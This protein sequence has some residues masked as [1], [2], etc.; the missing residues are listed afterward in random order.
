[1][2]KNPVVGPQPPAIQR[3]QEI[4]A[5]TL[6]ILGEYEEWYMTQFTT[7]L[8][9]D[10]PRLYVAIVPGVGHMVNMEAPEIFN[11]VVLSFLSDT[12]SA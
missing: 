10:M 7:L 1:V 11:S 9:Q 5:P 4:E 12:L 8:K 6:V 2:N 3:L